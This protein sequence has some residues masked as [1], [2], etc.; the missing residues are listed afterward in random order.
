M[1]ALASDHRCH[2]TPHRSCSHSCSTTIAAFHFKCC[3]TISSGDHGSPLLSGTK[4]SAS[5]RLQRATNRLDQVLTR[6]RVETQGSAPGAEQSRYTVPSVL[7]LQPGLRP[8]C[9]LASDVAGTRHLFNQGP[10]IW[11]VDQRGLICQ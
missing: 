8:A 11:I 5:V 9:V 2:S 10:V 6:H 4:S 3:L 1:S 7:E